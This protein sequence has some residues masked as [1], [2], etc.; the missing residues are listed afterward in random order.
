[1]KIR[2]CKK[3]AVLIIN[4]HIPMNDN[5][6][7]VNRDCRM[8]VKTVEKALATGDKS[9]LINFERTA[10]ITATFVG[11]LVQAYD[12]AQKQGITLKLSGLRD[13]VK[14]RL[15]MTKLIS[16]FEVFPNEREALRSFNGKSKRNRQTRR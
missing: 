9:I 2:A 1:M 12:R 8:L 6:N 16:L 13:R 7:F 14:E 11:S 15:V 5:R 4:V 3:G 10:W